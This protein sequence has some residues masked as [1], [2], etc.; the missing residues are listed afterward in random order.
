M[1]RYLKFI[2]VVIAAVATAPTLHAEHDELQRYLTSV[3][4]E[5][6]SIDFTNADTYFSES[7][8]KPIEGVWRF[9]GSEGMF[10][11]VAD[12][13]TIFYKII[14]VDSPDQNVL[15]GTVMGVCTEV[16]RQNHFDAQIF[17]ADEMGVMS[18]THRFTISLSDEGRLVI[19]PVVNKLKFNLWRLLPYMFR[20]SVKRVNNRPDNLDGA[21]R[22]YPPSETTPL[23]PR[24]L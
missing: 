6:D 15:P 10:A 11:I 22:L 9:S 4:H 5:R 23:S 19:V 1:S 16:G 20:H 13:A 21:I 24:Y 7:G 8:L 18:G 12:P 14:V 3:A 2:I 17:T